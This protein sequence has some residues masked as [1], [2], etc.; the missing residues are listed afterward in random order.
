[1]TNNIVAAL[2]EQATGG[3][4]APTQPLLLLPST[5]T[6]QMTHY[7]GSAQYAFTNDLRAQADFTREATQAPQSSTIA[8]AA[9]ALTSGQASLAF[10]HRFRRWRLQ[11]YY[12]FNDGSFNYAATGSSHSY[13]QR[14]N[15]SATVG[16]LASL[17]LTAGVNGS[18][19]NVGGNTNVHDRSAGANFAVSRTLWERWKVRATYDRQRDRY[20]FFATQFSSLLNG[21]T[22]AVLHPRVELSASH[23]MRD[24]LTF[25]ADPRL[26][27][28]S[29][30]QGGQLLG[31]FPG[32]LVVPSGANWS[33]AALAF[34][35]VQ[36]LTGRVAWL[37][38]RQKLLGAV[39]NSYREWEVS[40]G[41]K[42]RSISLDV[43]YLSHD[44]NFAVDVFN[45]NRFFFRVVREFTV[46]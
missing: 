24:G 36:K 40:A 9:S 16:S 41:Y 3:A 5:A 22:V 14:A 33:S 12:A 18:L 34:H 29:S 45:R 10:G 7:T 11:S 27:L 38:S 44:Q 6:L 37:D 46:F 17:E 8:S 4:V 1:V 25:Q 19:Q 35:P 20:N 26:Q 42:F 23:N 21:I 32:T 31:A 15:A 39:S 43:G 13:G 28:V 30:S 2:L